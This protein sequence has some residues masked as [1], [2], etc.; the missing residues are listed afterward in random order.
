MRKSN[1]EALRIFAMFGIVLHH[2]MVND[3]DVLGYN[4]PYLVSEGG[5]FPILNSIAVCGV[6]LFLLITGWFGVK[7]VFKKIISLSIMCFLIGSL[8]MIIGLLSPVYESSVRNN[9]LTIT[10]LH[11]WFIKF[12]FILLV[13][14]P[15]LEWIIGKINKNQL[16]FL[17]LV[18]TILN[19]VGCWG[20]EIIHDNSQGYSVLNFIYMYL[21]GRILKEFS[22]AK[23][24]LLLKKDGIYL[25]AIIA[26][27]SGFLF[28]SLNSGHNTIESGKYWAY[29]GPLVLT[30]AM[31]IF[32]HFSSL[33]FSNKYINYVASSA[34]IV[35]LAHSNLVMGYYRNMM[36]DAITDK[37]GLLL[38]LIVAAIIV[39]MIGTIIGTGIVNVQKRIMGLIYK[40]R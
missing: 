17:F 7:S 26:V 11:S 38:G 20:F 12:Y 34:L 3:L 25:V 31:L 16:L 33:D 23:F 13:V 36:T 6:D 40:G 14:S 29:N 18:L 27:A 30:L 39:Y 10:S 9:F 21:M 2:L 32:L 8:C 1:F 19:V 4:K 28:E 35:Y 22:N 24:L 5:V 15:V 37:I